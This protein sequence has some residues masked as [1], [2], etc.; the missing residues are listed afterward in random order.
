VQINCHLDLDQAVA[1][2]SGELVAGGLGLRRKPPDPDRMYPV[3]ETGP[4]G[5]PVTPGDPAEVAALAKLLA[6]VVLPALF[7][8]DAAV[9]EPVPASRGCRRCRT[10]A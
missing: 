2:P 9:G 4:S 7:A 6:E 10:W 1:S 5:L 8:S 3:R